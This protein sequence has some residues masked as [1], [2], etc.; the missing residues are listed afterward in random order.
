MLKKYIFFLFFV[1]GSVY[2]QHSD[3]PLSDYEQR[4]I[5]NDK[6]A[7]AISLF[8]NP[9]S[10]FLKID[11]KGLHINR[12]EIVSLLGGKEK[13]LNS[14]FKSI[15]LGDLPRGIYLIKIYSDKG[16]TVKKMIKK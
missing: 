3:K 9:V 4:L 8:P 7:E 11:S 1:C 13:E 16:Y 15:Y 2:A 12:I 14:N 10:E 6:L 5:E